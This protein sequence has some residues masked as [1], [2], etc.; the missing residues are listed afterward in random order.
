M[1]T[2]F[3][4]FLSVHDVE[5]L[6]GVHHAATLQVVDDVRAV[7]LSRCSCDGSRVFGAVDE[8]AVL[9][10]SNVN[11]EISLVGGAVDGRAIVVG[12]VEANLASIAC[13]QPH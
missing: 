7:F 2:L 8:V 6:H 12:P 9:G 4:D 11:I 5:T 1:I 10:R 13:S 3:D